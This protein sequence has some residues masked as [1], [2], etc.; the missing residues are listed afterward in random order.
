MVK[1]I[2]VF[3]D[4]L[5][6][7]PEKQKSVP[8]AGYQMP[9]RAHVLRG[10]YRNS[11]ER[12][13]PFVP[14]QVTSVRFELPDVAHTL[15]PGHRIMVQVQSSWLPLLDRNPHKYVSIYE[16]ESRTSRGRRATSTTTRSAR[17]ACGC[18]CCRARA[19]DRIALDMRRANLG[20]EDR[21]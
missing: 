5:R 1:L 7:Y 16:A 9:V 4:S 19:G 18:G 8:M 13:E 3:R 10:R 6:G 20:G 2:D 21:P 17:R 15:E 12:P 11:F 14:G